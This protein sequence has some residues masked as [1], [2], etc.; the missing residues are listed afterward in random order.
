MNENSDGDSKDVKVG[1]I[2]IDGR[3]DRVGIVNREKSERRKLG[4]QFGNCTNKQNQPMLRANSSGVQSQD[5]LQ[6]K[7]FGIGE[8]V[9]VWYS[10]TLCG[11]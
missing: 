8:H 6:I 10:K 9:T 5:L 7:K 4:M 2:E 3:Q 1:R 11:P